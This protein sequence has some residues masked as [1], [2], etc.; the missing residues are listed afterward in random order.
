MRGE[1]K[2]S[3]ITAGIDERDASESSDATDHTVGNNGNLTPWPKG[4]S[5][6][7]RGRPRGSRARFAERL[8]DDVIDLWERRGRD[9]LEI[10]F[11]REPVQM[12]KAFIGILPREVLV[13]ALNF[14]ATVDLSEMEKQRGFLEAFRYARD[15]IG[16]QPLEDIAEG[17]LITPGWRADDE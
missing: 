13:Q 15:R 2:P 9:G 17:S 3:T 10:A 16:A 1:H 8:L 4:K 12:I 7:P 11:T 14:N 5:G 6:N